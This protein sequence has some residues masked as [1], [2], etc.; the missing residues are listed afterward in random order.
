VGEDGSAIHGL[1]PAAS[2]SARMISALALGVVILGGVSAVVHRP[3][4]VGRG[5]ATISEEHARDLRVPDPVAPAFAAPDP[6]PIRPDK[7]DSVWA[8]IERPTPVQARPAPDSRVLG[9]LSTVTPEGTD[10]LVLIF[11]REVGLDNRLWVRVSFPS[12]PNGAAGWVPRDALG[13][14]GMVHTRLVIDLG[15]LNARLY[16]K[17]RIVFESPVGI[18]EPEWPTPIGNFYIRNRLT[19]FADPFY[20]PVAFG[21]SARSSVLTDWPAGGFVGIHGTDRPELL[22]G[23]VSHGCVRMRNRDILK[24]DRLMPVG[25]PVTIRQ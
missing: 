1:K 12:L 16:D 19:G 13:G 17:G 7:W 8:I 24:L 2:R 22:P 9:R 4:P 14:Y 3:A 6:R 10:N 15:A 25:T 20:G 21:T 11:D 23:P 5:A 18:G